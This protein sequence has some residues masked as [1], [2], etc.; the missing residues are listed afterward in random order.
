MLRVRHVA[1]YLLFV[2]SGAAGLG[3]QM[4]W[5]RMF[6][7]GLGHETPSMLAIVSAFMGGMALGAWTFDRRIARSRQPGRWY[8]ALEAVIGLWAFVSV[9]LIPFANS[10][11]LRLVGIDPSALRH[12]IIAFAIP[13]LAL[14]P[15][16]VAMG[17]T[18]RRSPPMR[19]EWAPYMRRIPSEQ[20]P[21]RS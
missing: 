11:A 18:F 3:Y 16:T 19:G 9:A 14:L 4:T 1:I 7:T 15:A 20:W 6:A 12:W 21:A 8:A 2:F 17:A 10:A 5:T 13:L